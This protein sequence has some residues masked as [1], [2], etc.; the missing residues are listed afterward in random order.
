M[1]SEVL[2]AEGYSLISFSGGEPLLYSPLADVMKRARELGFRLTMIT[3]GLLAKERK[4]PVLDLFDGIAISFDGLAP[5][6]N[7]MRRRADAFER[8]SDALQRLASRGRPVAAA[9]SV[10]KDAIS[11][12]PDLVDHVVSL[13]ARA[14]QIRPVARAG[15]A[16]SLADT[17]FHSSID[18][19]RL[20]LVVLALQEE[21]Q[22]R[23]RVHC[24]LAPAQGL[25]QQRDAYAGLLGTVR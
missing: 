14:V 4:D 22:S 6:H 8:A 12:L 3:N 24:D 19:A 5:T 18:H 2:R 20:Y 23:V 16:R 25:W 13:G 11:E 1:P 10:T 21:L 17:A 9:I 7:A 15:R